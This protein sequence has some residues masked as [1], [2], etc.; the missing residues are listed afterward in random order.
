[1]PRGMLS[2]PRVII[3]DHPSIRNECLKLFQNNNN[4][5][6][7]LNNQILKHVTTHHLPLIVTKIVAS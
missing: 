1:M 6:N 3:Y 5:N 2:E 7:I 4:N